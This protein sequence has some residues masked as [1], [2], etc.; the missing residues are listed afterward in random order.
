M[1]RQG[2]T[3]A[4]VLAGL[5]FI[6]PHVLEDF[7]EGIARR[8]GLSTPAAACHGPAVPAAVLAWRGR[9]AGEARSVRG[10]AILA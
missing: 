9:R 5:P 7:A 3:I 4:A 8:V 2:W 1:S 10:G 6:L